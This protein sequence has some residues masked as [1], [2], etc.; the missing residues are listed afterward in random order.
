MGQRLSSLARIPGGRRTKFAMIGVWLLI[1][2]AIGPLSN[3]FEDAQKNDPADYLPGNAES[4]EALNKVNELPSGEEADA[5]TVFNR[6]GGLTAA[7][8]ATIAK[9]RAEI[10]ANRRE[11]QRPTR[12]PVVSDDKTTALLFTPIQVENGTNKAGERLVDVT[13]DIKDTISD[14][15]EGLEARVT[16]PAGFSADAIAV[17]N[18]INGTLL[19]ATALLVLILLIVIYRSP[20]FWVIP[21]FSVLIAETVTRGLGY[22]LAD[23]GVTVTGQ[24]GGILPV[25]V[26]GAGTDYA[27]LLVSRYREELRHHDDKHEAILVALRTAGPAILASGLTVMAALLTLTLAEVNGTAGLGPIGAMGVF[28]AMISMLTLL[29]A[30]LT[31]AGRRAFWPFIPRVGTTG[32]DET[33]GRWRKIAEWVGR[34]PRRVWIGTL[35]LLLFFCLGLTQVNTDLTSGN[36]FRGD[37]ESVEGQKLVN[38]GFP[39]GA[40]APTN[41]FVTDPAKVPAVRRALQGA[42]GVAEVGAMERGESGVN[43]QVTLD[44]DP[45]STAA[46]DLIPGIRDR[47]HAVAGDDVLVGGPTAEERDLRVSSTRDNRL[48]VPIALIV[49]FF[50]LAALLRAVVAPLVLIGTV[51]VSFAAALGIGAFFF[52][53]VFDFAGM[54]PSLP[55]FAFIFLVALGIDY[56]IFLMARVREETLKEGTRLGMIRGL[57]VTGGVITSAGLVLAGTFS[58]LAVLPLVGLTEIGFT[59]AIGVL[60][61]TFIVRSLLVPALVLEIGDRV[62]WPSALARTAGDDGQQPAAGD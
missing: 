37:V 16:G 6:D 57:A 30:L 28:I 15:P 41:V 32:A 54:D 42:P 52:E 8:A 1:V 35:A 12:P 47:V 9:D 23:A 46:F 11:G 61:D 59:V 44:Q 40:N 48:I 36:S 13:D 29:P 24:S 33:H 2:F 58:A 17:F 5:I 55:L 10:N 62:W 7:D 49:V 43:I 18:D 21:F 60:I 38:E 14:S 45:Y 51:I 22:L 27:L 20:I 53:H 4:V 34:G 26:F 3:K 25:L 31:L 56:N 19:Y 39:A 50:I